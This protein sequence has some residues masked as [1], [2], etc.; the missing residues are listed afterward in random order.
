M[1]PMNGQ[2]MHV[3]VIDPINPAIERVKALL[4]APFDLG[5]WFIIGFCAWLA[6]LSRYNG[7]GVVLTRAAQGLPT[8]STE[9]RTI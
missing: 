1:S 2:E 6:Q 9:P 8:R 7:G 4:F 5:R 3:S